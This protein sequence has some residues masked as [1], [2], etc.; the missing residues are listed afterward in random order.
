MFDFAARQDGVVISDEIYVNVSWCSSREYLNFVTVTL[1]IS[2]LHEKN[3]FIQFNVCN[4]MV[5]QGI[6][7]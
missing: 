4:N 7:R 6:R 1:L 5:F 3:G 2:G